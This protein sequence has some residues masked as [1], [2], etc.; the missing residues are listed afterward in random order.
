LEERASVVQ[1]LLIDYVPAY[2]FARVEAL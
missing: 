1:Q 2:D